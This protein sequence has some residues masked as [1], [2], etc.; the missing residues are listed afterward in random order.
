MP[1]KPAP[2]SDTSWSNFFLFLVLGVISVSVPLY[3]FFTY[4]EP[5]QFQPQSPGGSSFTTPVGAGN[6]GGGPANVYGSGGGAFNPTLSPGGTFG[7][8]GGQ[9]N[10]SGG[11]GG[12]YGPGQGVYGAPNMGSGIFGAASGSSG[13]FLNAAG[14]PPVNSIHSSPRS[15]YAS[16]AAG[17]W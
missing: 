17:Q 10:V 9:Q 7:M 14:R 15:P 6:I 3:L 13:G 16:S 11:L 1:K 2:K 8:P 5:Q 4:Y 12:Q